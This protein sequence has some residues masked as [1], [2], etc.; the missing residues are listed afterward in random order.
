MHFDTALLKETYA[1]F[2][3]DKVPRL[4][5]A[6]S[7]TTIFAIAP[8]FIVVIAIAGTALAFAGGTGHGHGTIEESLLGAVRHAAGKEAADTVRTMVAASFAH[9][10]QSI[11]AQVVGWIALIAGAGALFAALQDALN[12]IWH[13][14]PPKKGLW[15]AVRDRLASFGMLL[16]IGFLLLVTTA[17]NAGIGIVATRLMSLLPF[18]GAGTVF[19]IVN[20]IVSIALIA[21]LFALMYKYLPDVPIAW[22]DVRI[23]ALVTAVAFVIGQSLIA[24][25][26]AHAGI[27]SGYGAA[28]SLLVL[29][30]WVYYSSLLLLAGAEFTAVYAQRHGSHAASADGLRPDSGAPADQAS[31]RPLLERLN[32]PE[33]RPPADQKAQAR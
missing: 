13:A 29:L 24:F 26:I 19:T 17:V 12:T 10:G 28:G 30:I 18:P 25:Y 33:E 1:R 27:G 2:S 3:V 4:A 9:R 6:L 32:A 21:L 11:V 31:S 22:S 16:A 23:G 14:E 7:Y 5:A 20:W 8:I 15:P